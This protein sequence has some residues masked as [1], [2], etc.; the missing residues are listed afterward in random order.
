[1]TEPYPSRR[2]KYYVQKWIDTYCVV[3]AAESQNANEFYMHYYM[4][5]VE[6]CNLC[7]LDNLKKLLKII[8]ALN[9][10]VELINKRIVIGIRLS[11]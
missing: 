4:W 5:G 11:N 1:M 2:R 3:G 10:K 9:Y 8:K 6:N 7:Q